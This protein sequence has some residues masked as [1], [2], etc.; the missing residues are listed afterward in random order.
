MYQIADH[1]YQQA[2]FKG[3]FDEIP[4]SWVKCG[5]AAD[6]R[7]GLHADVTC[8]TDDGEPVVVRHGTVIALRAAVGVAM[9][10]GELTLAGDFEPYE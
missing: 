5:L 2:E 4:E 1:P 6:E 7:N 10:A 3:I 8:L 9:H